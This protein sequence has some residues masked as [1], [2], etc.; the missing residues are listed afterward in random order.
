M[1]WW[2]YFPIRRFQ[3][4]PKPASPQGMRAQRMARTF[5]LSAESIEKENGPESGDGGSATADQWD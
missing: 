1:G 3:P 2:I 4:P 5:S